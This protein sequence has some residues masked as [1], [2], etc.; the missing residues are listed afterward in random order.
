M[1]RRG[2]G[3]AVKQ[4]AGRG[5]AEDGDGGAFGVVRGKIREII[6]GA[7][8]NPRGGEIVRIRL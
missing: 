4:F 8:K 2:P 6:T 1:S 7:G 5:D 3:A